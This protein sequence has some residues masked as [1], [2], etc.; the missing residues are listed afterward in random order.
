MKKLITTALSL[1][2]LSG[3]LSSCGDKATGSTDN[4]EENNIS[5]A[6]EAADSESAAN[7]NSLQE[8]SGA[9]QVN[10]T[11]DEA[12]EEG[13]AAASVTEAEEITVNAAPSDTA[14]AGAQTDKEQTSQYFG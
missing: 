7:V 2:L 1:I 12:S 10:A 6:A 8:T 14:E 13:T 11:D 9:T 3:M 4:T 5:V